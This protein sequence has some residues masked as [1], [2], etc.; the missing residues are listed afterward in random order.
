MTELEF[1]KNANKTWHTTMMAITE[2]INNYFM[3]E[4]TK[5]EPEQLLMKIVSDLMRIGGDL[6]TKEMELFDPKA[7][8]GVKHVEED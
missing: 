3:S 7:K 6:I 2:E 4:P 1:Y 8:E 5:K